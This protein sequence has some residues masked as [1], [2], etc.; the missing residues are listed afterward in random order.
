[1]KGNKFQVTIS[2]RSRALNIKRYILNP[3]QVNVPLME[4]L[5]SWFTSKISKK[6]LWK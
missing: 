2:T 1:M 6:H 4:K 3:F 5:G